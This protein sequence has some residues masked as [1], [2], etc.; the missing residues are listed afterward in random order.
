MQTQQIQVNELLIQTRVLQ[1]RITTDVPPFVLIHGLSMSSRY[2]LPTAM[3]LGDTHPVFVPDLPG[4]GDSANPP[5]TLSIQ[6]QADFLVAWLDVLAL[7]RPIFL[8]NS[9]GCQ[10]LVDL[11][12]RYP[13]RVKT[14]ILTA[15]ALDPYYHGLVPHFW[16][17]V[18]DT[19]REKPRLLWPLLLD[20]AKSRLL[21]NI[22]TFRYARADAMRQKLPRVVAPTL[23]LRGARDPLVSQRWAEEVAALL[24]DAQLQ[25]LVDAPHDVTFSAP[26]QVVAVV[27]QFLK[28]K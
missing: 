12:A 4:F 21:R 18:L 25:I 27:R 7:R 13:A 6:E 5:H 3:R 2:L 24:P 15:P 22:R 11:A 20:F 26:A 1:P 28:D 10:I 16:R 9:L 14:L 17:L 19:P 23:V 8:G